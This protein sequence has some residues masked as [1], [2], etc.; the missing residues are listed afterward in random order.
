MNGERW[1]NTCFFLSPSKAD[2]LLKPKTKVSQP[3]FIHSPQEIFLTSPI[4]ICSV[5]PRH[6]PLASVFSHRKCLT[7]FSYKALHFFSRTF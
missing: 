2:K 3:K 4:F 7:G 5:V 1:P 6:L